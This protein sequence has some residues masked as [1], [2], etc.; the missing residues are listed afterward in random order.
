MII[1]LEMK[2][3]SLYLYQILINHFGKQN[4]WPVDGKY[5]EKNGTDPRFEII[6]GAILTQNTAWSNVEKALEN[7][8]SERLLDI[9]IISKLGEE[10]LKKMIKPTGFFNQKATRLKNLAEYLESK[11]SGNL[12]SFFNKELSEIKEE[13]LSLNGVGPETADSILLYAGNQ[14]IF[15]VDAYT[16]RIC[17]RLPL[18][19]NPVYDEI[20]RY[21]QDN[22]LKK[23][24][25]NEISQ[26][27]NELHALIVILGKTFCKSK[28]NCIRCPLEKCCNYSKKLT[29]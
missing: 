18:N 20:Q 17:K 9:K 2:L 1:E 28:P 13:L 23:Y 11:Y 3:N 25:K 8:K 24:K 29:Q 16:K 21:F 12:D 19:I 4:W 27:Y 10:L 15:V 5:H 22:L 6:V 26:I 14:P 7:L